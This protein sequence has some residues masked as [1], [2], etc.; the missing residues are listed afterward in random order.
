MKALLIILPLL[1]T[2]CI[3][4]KKG[5]IKCYSGNTLI[6]EG[7]SIGAI[8]NVSYS[9]NYQFRELGTD[10]FMEVSGNCIIKHDN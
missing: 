2:S 9:D 3:D 7:K 4:D 1:L 8:S 6:Y 10:N 5:S